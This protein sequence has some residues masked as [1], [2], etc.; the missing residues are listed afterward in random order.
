MRVLFFGHPGYGGAVLEQLLQR[1]DVTVIAVV[2]ASHDTWHNL[3]R[4]LKRRFGTW[5][6]LRKNVAKIWRNLPAKGQAR[7][8]HPHSFATIDP[9]SLAR[10]RRIPLIDASRLRDP[11]FVSELESM[12]VDLL[13]V[14]SFGELI[15]SSVLDVARV[16]SINMHPGLLPKH[17]GGFPEYT[18]LIQGDF[19]AGI[20]CHLMTS[21]FDTGAVLLQDSLEIG[22]DD[23]LQLKKRMMILAAR[24]VNHLLDN[25]TALL[26]TAQ[27]QDESR[28]TSCKY[29]AG[30]DRLRSDEPVDVVLRKIR[31]AA[32]ENYE[33]YFLSAT[34]QKVYVLHLSDTAGQ[35][36]PF[37]CSDGV[38]WLD[39][40][41]VRR[42][43]VTNDFTMIQ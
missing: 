7:Y 42:R 28:A 41:R 31:A 43:I 29:P 9:E 16:A 20:T 3:K 25:L 37:T 4:M 12:H 11:G 8:Q 24:M 18:A 23:L 5:K 10:E 6:R 33:P 27:P 21:T 40:L 38:V 36:Y 34:G 15:P 13:L 26:Q 22:S 1:S 14:A 30:F 19:T 35:G 2:H 39:V 17:R 32:G